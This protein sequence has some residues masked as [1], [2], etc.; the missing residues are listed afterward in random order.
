MIN[1]DIYFPAQWT[2]KQVNH[3]LITHHSPDFRF[4]GKWR[5]SIRGVFKDKELQKVLFKQE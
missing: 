1:L 2:D 3:W 5:D 4:F